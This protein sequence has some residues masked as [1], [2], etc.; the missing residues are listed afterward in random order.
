MLT[1]PRRRYQ[2]V[3]VKDVGVD[4]MLVVREIREGDI[5]KI[6]VALRRRRNSAEGEV[7]FETRENQNDASLR[8]PVDQRALLCWLSD[9]F[10]LFQPSAIMQ[11]V[12]R[13]KY[14]TSE[15]CPP[16]IGCPVSL[17]SHLR[18]KQF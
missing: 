13:H 16:L 12:C 14:K 3:A 18:M 7:M 2:I 8:T 10:F 5:S 6:E 4:K 17:N 9:V 11:H 15:A 1:R